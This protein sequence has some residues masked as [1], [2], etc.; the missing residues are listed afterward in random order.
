MQMFHTKKSLGG[1]DE[2]HS[3]IPCWA[4][5][6]ATKEFKYTQR[7]VLGLVNSGNPPDFPFDAQVCGFGDVFCREG[8]SK[9]K[10]H[11]TGRN[12]L[13]LRTGLLTQVYTR[14]AP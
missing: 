1:S 5:T 7:E 8:V 10:A 14:E 6:E 3:D 12:I 11:H 13:A 4:C 2:H 9:W